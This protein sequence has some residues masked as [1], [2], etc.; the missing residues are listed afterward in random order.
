MT[1]AI[2]L[3][4]I[5]SENWRQVAK[6]SRTLTETQRMQ[7]ADNAYSMLEAIYEY[8][9]HTFAR[10]AYAGD[11][12]VGFVMYGHEQKQWWIIRLMVAYS[13]QGKGYGRAIMK[14]VIDI[15]KAKPEAESLNISFVPG[16]DVAQKLYASLGF[17]DTGIIEDGEHVY[18]LTF[19]R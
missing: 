19:E 7:V 16:N 4:E 9:E 14:R 12:L 18:K 3:K 2:S 6:L 10:A 8:P 5:S 13:E 1:Q 17:A 15:V 11:E